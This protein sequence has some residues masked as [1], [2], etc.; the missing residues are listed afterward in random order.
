MFKGK[1]ILI[2]HYVTKEAK[3]N[4]SITLADELS[5]IG[6][7][8]FKEQIEYG[9]QLFSK[10]LV[11]EYKAIKATL[12]VVTFS[13]IFDNTHK[14]ENILSYSNLMIIDV[15]YLAGMDLENK[16]QEIFLDEH[17]YAIWISPSGAGLKILI[18]I[19]STIDTHRT[20]FSELCN[21]L[22]NKYG[23]NVE[24]SGSDICRLCFTSYDVNILIKN[25]CKQFYVNVEDILTSVLPIKPKGS[26][27]KSTNKVFDSRIEKFLFFA[28]E[29]KNRKSDRDTI[30]KIIKFLKGKKLSITYDYENW[31]KVALAI[32]NT[33][34]YDLGQKY[35][36]YLCELDGDKH[37]EYK[38]IY[39]LQYCYRN[40]KLNKVNF[41]TIIYLAEEKGFVHNNQIS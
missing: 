39:N 19:L 12:P 32:A 26:I 37:E 3:N 22:F 33:F 7:G 15:D 14:A 23:I 35:Y 29:G 41:A 38:S 11:K 13:G 9:R 20:Y 36:L 21:Y 16:K 24:K 8:I 6:N 28:T 30:D 5:K 17:V 2:S 4:I 10:G 27:E 40:R 18:P 1:N 31:Y 34:T 25:E